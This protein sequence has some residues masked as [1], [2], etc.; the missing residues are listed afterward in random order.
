[1]TINE[2]LKD[3]LEHQ[4]IAENF[5]TEMHNDRE[6]FEEL[7]NNIQELS[8]PTFYWGGSYGK[9]TMIKD[10]YDIDILC[11]FPADDSHPLEEIYMIVRDHIRSIEPNAYQ[12]NVAIRVEKREGYHIDIVPAKR[13]GSD[14]SMAYLYKSQENRRLTTSVEKQIQIV[15]D[16]R[17]RDLLKLIKLWKSRNNIDIPSFLVEIITIQVNEDEKISIEGGLKKV[18]K[19]IASRIETCN[20]PD[21]ANA[22]NNIASDEVTAPSEKKRAKEIAEWSLEQDLDALEGWK[23][24]FRRK[25]ES[26]NFNS[27]NGKEKRTQSRLSPDS[28][29]SRFA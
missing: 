19:F 26:F 10:S 6:Y 3:L 12:K 1:M 21:P 2:F 28:P 17:R 14:E 27:R 22:S 16:F 29:G 24:I 4:T 18:F 23:N 9:N 25:K 11:Y 20:I 15:R 13:S 7:I 8:R 5:T